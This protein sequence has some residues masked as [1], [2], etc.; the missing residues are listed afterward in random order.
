M[1]PLSMAHA[2]QQQPKPSGAV[3]LWRLLGSTELV[4]VVIAWLFNIIIVVQPYMVC[5]RQ[6]ELMHLAIINEKHCRSFGATRHMWVRHHCE[7]VFNPGLQRGIALILWQRV[8][9]ACDV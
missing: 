3:V 2:G 4:G 7:G 6:P 5:S 1:L 8:T 9:C